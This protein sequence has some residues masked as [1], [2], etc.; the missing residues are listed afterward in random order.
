MQPTP[1]VR[2]DRLIKPHGGRLVNRVLVSDARDNAIARARS[3]KRIALNART[4]SDLELIAGGAFSPLEGFMGQ[5]DY[6]TVLTE[7]RLANGLPWSLPIT[8]AVGESDAESLKVGEEVALVAP[9]DELLGLLHLEEKFRLDKTEEARLV[10]GTEEKRHPGVAYL[11]TRGELLLAGRI[12][13]VNHPP[14]AGFEA[15][16]RDPA[17][18]RAF[19]EANQW[20]TVVGFQTRNPIHR[21][22]EYIQKCALE[23]MDGILIHPLVGK[24][25]LDDI[26]SEVRLR[27]YQA[28]IEHYYPKDRVLLS[29]FPGAM[30]YAGPRE[31]IFHALVRKNYGCTHFIVGRDHAGVG[32]FYHPFAAHEIFR[33]FNREELDIVP[34]FFDETFFCKRCG[35]VASPKTCPHP[36]EERV[37]L[38]GTRVRELL[39]QGESLPPE[40]TRPE[41][42][43]VL[44][45]WIQSGS[46]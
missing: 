46:A 26:P 3:L 14:L 36:K 24:T 8:L 23:L 28:L 37:A 12:D 39:S 25:K 17:E 35:A 13:L 41:V 22:H 30:R 15:Y 19:F 20:R 43:E 9:W 5:A 38:S 2:R 32:N 40:F 7:M 29:V 11:Y 18:T 10:Y 42:A 21:S 45:E 33:K 6:S 34:L 4:M 31:A 44:A 27:C 16:R 1:A